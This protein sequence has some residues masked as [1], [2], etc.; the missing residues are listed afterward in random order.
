MPYRAP[1]PY[2]YRSRSRLM[3]ALWVWWNAECNQGEALGVRWWSPHWCV[4]RWRASWYSDD[5]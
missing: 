4:E 1:K 2:L 5:H 3:C